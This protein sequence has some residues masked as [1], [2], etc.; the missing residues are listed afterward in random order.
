MLEDFQ[1]EVISEHVIVT[2]VLDHYDR[3]SWINFNAVMVKPDVGYSRTMDPHSDP[4][5]DHV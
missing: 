2:F 5:G 3:K 4:Y 1:R